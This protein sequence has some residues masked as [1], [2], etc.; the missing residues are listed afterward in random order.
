MILVDFECRNCHKIEEKLVDAGQQVDVCECGG[1]QDRIISIGQVYTANEDAPWLRSV[2]E[3]VDK[4]S[5]KPHVR[6]FI[7]NPTRSN[8][9]A[10]MKGEGLRPMDSNVRGAPPVYQK[11]QGPDPAK[12]RKELIEKHI[13]RRRIEL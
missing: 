1:T 8:Y 3:V 9:K 5:S 2:L 12:I 10:W 7:K 6:E 13:A 11:P 4:D